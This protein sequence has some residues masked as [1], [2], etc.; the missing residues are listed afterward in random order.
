MPSASGAL[1]GTRPWVHQ[2]ATSPEG[3]RVRFTARGDDVHVIAAGSHAPTLT[4]ADVAVAPTGTVHT[5]DGTPLAFTTQADGSVVIDM[6]G[7]G[8]DTVWPAALTVTGARA[9][10]R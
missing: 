8:P 10:A 6:T 5:A 4:L 1:V 9:R 3:H 2:A 7:L